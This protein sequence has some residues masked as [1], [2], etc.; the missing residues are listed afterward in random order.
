MVVGGGQ[1]WQVLVKRYEYFVQKM[2]LQVARL[3]GVGLCFTILLGTIY[4]LGP[5]VLFMYSSVMLTLANFKLA[6][7]SDQS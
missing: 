2:S 5:P 3:V 4:F 1:N 6:L 7:L